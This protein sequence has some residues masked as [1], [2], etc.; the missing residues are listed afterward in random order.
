MVRDLF[1]TPGL[2]LRQRL[3]HI[4]WLFVLLLIGTASVGFA[5]LYSAANGTLEPWALRQMLRFGAGMI[6][7]LAVA[8][9]NLRLWLQYA[10]VFYAIT[11]GLLA[12]LVLPVACEK[13]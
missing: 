10:Y 2:T 13:A 3:W 8:M 4:H 6:V 9:T 1:N 5:M 7:M 11:L 12:V